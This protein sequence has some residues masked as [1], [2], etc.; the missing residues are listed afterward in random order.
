MRAQWNLTL[1]V[2]GA[3]VVNDAIDD[4]SSITVGGT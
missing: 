4:H 2:F 1:K 3:N